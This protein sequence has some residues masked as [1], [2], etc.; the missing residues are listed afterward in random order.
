[1][2][3]IGGLSSRNFIS[4]GSRI[5]GKSS[6]KSSSGALT[7]GRVGARDFMT[8]LVDAGETL[9]SLNI[10]FSN[11]TS[12]SARSLKART[13]GNSR[14][15][16]NT[17][18][19]KS[20]LSSSTEISTATTGVSDRT[21]NWKNT[22]KSTS[23]ATIH[24]TYTGTSDQTYEIKSGRTRGWTVGKKKY[25]FKFYIDG[26]RQSNISVPG[27]YAP[28]DTISIGDG[29]EVSFGAG[30]IT[31]RDTLTFDGLAGLDVT[32]D[33]DE[34]FDGSTGGYHNLDSTVTS[35]TFEV[36]GETIT[37]AATDTINTVIDSINAS[38]AGVTAE[39][40]DSDDSVTLT[41]N[42]GGANTISVGSDTSG[43]LAAVK[44]DTAT[45]DLG[46]EDERTD[47]IDQVSLLGGIASGSFDINGVSISID[48]TTDSLNDIISRV[49]SSSADAVMSYSKTTDRLSIRSSNTDAELTVEN[50]TTGL[51]TTFGIDEGT[52]APKQAKGLRSAVID[53][54][55]AAVSEMVELVNLMSRTVQNEAVMGDSVNDARDTLR[56]YMGN[57]FEGKSGDTIDSGLGLKFNV[58]DD[59]TGAFIEL[60]TTG[61]KVLE[62]A[63]K[64]KP[65]EVLE[66][67][68]GSKERSGLVDT[69]LSGLD[70]AQDGII[71]KYGSVGLTLDIEA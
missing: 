45:I 21:L 52:S 6:S 13:V 27:S 63:L 17:S 11:V 53:E 56:T 16:L 22:V 64:R 62:R 34:A 29:L 26:V 15:E 28:G 50:D 69:M 30:A 70:K 9:K 35:G 59:D 66:M 8:R 10:K 68:F 38:G 33:P 36:N 41:H 51:F 5:G 65:R 44:L 7:A 43:F 57:A 24:G 67:L 61:E 3:E 12:G 39:Y 32:A 18:G 47:A 1:M 48:V 49:N 42:S 71:S 58:G 54:I 60:G 4:N 55:I 14:V 31:K 19:T 25:A 46:K 2:L 20:T 40:N 23:T 37:V